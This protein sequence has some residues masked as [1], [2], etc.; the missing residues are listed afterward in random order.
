MKRFL[1]ILF[2]TIFW[3]WNFTFLFAVYVGLL[4]VI[5]IFL[6]EDTLSGLVPLDFLLTF[7][8]LIA[9]PTVSTLIGIRW[10]RRQPR[11]LLRLF[12]GVE[13]P[14]VLL[15]SLRLF[16][17]RE[18][19][20]ASLFVLSTGFI[21]MIAFFADIIIER[22]RLTTSEPPQYHPILGY[23]RIIISPLMFLTGL[24][25]GTLILFFAIPLAANIIIGFF[26]FHWL[27]ELRWFFSYNLQDLFWTIIGFSLLTF[28]VTLFVFMPSA[29]ASLYIHSSLQTFKQSIT[30][31]SRKRVLQVG[32][33]T[34]TAWVIVLVSV[35]QQ[36]QAKAFELLE[37]PTITESSRQE[38]LNQSD[39]IQK[40]LINAYLSS[41]RYL[42][43]ANKSNQIRNIYD[44]T[45]G[46]S[47]E[48]NQFIQDRFNN[49]ISPFLYQGYRSDAEKAEKLYAEFF[50]IPIQKGE[51]KAILHAIQ[52]TADRDQAKAGLLNIGQKKVWLRSQEINITEHGDFADIELYEIYDNKTTD[53]EEILYYFSL[54]ESAV[55]TGIW[56]GDTGD[57]AKRFP[58]QVSPRGAAQK[59][60]T[61]QVRRVNPV[62]P[63]LLEQVGPRQ[64]RLRAFP[65]PP[66]ITPAEKRREVE[67]PTEMHLWLTYQVMRQDKSWQLPQLTE[68]RN[69][70]WTQKTKR[71]YNGKPVIGDNENWLPASL[72]ATKIEPKT[73]HSVSFDNNNRI[74]AQP[75]INQQSVLPS[76]KR[77]AVILDTSRSMASQRQSVIDTFE[78]L[79]KQGLADS[80]INNNDADLYLS[81][82]GDISPQRI[83]EISEFQPKNITFYGTLQPEKMLQQFQQLKTDTAY[84]G[85]F[86]LTDEGSYELAED[87]PDIPTPA[88]PLWMVHFGKTSPAYEDGL[89]AAIQNSQGGVANSMAEV[90]QRMGLQNQLG[91][92][93]INVVDGYVWLSQNTTEKTIISNTDLTPIASRQW[94]QK[95]SREMD[96]QQLDQLDAIHAIAKNSKIVTPYSSMIVLVN[97]EQRQALKEAEAAADRFDRTVENGKEDLTQPDNPLNASVPEPGLVIGLIGIGFLLLI[98]RQ[99]VRINR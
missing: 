27:R 97:D 58:F 99:K 90:L 20:S 15:C 18:M 83:D 50:D 13:A 19:T 7:I 75:L 44:Y 12:Y 60:Y 88:A 84:D 37:N 52:S 10:F 51:Q 46:L 28:S 49:L 33:A 64:Y 5:G 38:L 77:F 91:E 29:L 57:L 21:C 40:G 3:F 71:I 31:F 54:P 48:F 22:Q 16:V 2:H 61:S 69:I 42:S 93:A 73:T 43:P 74:V 98:P 87:L 17:I 89:L 63:A 30:Q 85:I 67:R 14:L 56:L 25:V 34:I 65:V 23:L 39:L 80:K 70:F 92:T 36:P 55:I 72:P 95:L 68:K 41:Y 78:W 62:D 1:N 66:P 86:I 11:Q 79:K 94:V 45:F 8:G 81:A 47:Q 6:I 82:T 59:V 26:Q 4:P 32:V 76:G 24:Y 9:I 96:L 35:Q 53:V